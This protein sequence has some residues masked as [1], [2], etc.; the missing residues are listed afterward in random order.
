M[1]RLR[2]R[3]CADAFGFRSFH[4]LRR[5]CA[6]RLAAEQTD[7]QKAKAMFRLH[8]ELLLTIRFFNTDTIDIH[9]RY[10]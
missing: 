10:I 1:K 3:R 2:P 8:H 9:P 5:E 7:K 6:R 4:G